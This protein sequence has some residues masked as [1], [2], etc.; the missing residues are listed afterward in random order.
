[1]PHKHSSKRYRSS[2]A[3]MLNSRIGWLTIFFLSACIV[4]LWPKFVF[5]LLFV[6]GIAILIF[7]FVVLANR[8]GF[9]YSDAAALV[10]IFLTLTILLAFNL[11][12]PIWQPKQY[13]TEAES[14]RLQVE[15]TNPISKN[16]PSHKRSLSQRALH[17]ILAI[18]REW[19]S[20]LQR[21]ATKLSTFN[22]IVIL[23]LLI[24]QS[25]IISIH[26]FRL[27]LFSWIPNKSFEFVAALES[28]LTKRLF[29][30]L[31]IE[32]WHS[33]LTGI[34]I[35]VALKL[36][37]FHS[38]LSYGIFTAFAVMIPRWG[39]VLAISLPTIQSVTTTGIGIHIIGIFLAFATTTLISHALFDQTLQRL[40]PNLSFISQILSL[41][42]AAIIAGLFGMLL[43]IPVI[44][45]FRIIWL[46]I[47]ESILY[48]DNSQCNTLQ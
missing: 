36:L 47:D 37:G 19:H 15:P 32:L 31:Y 9:E 23:V 40:R 45:V 46:M 22:W 7:P 11:A 48:L 8:C 4:L 42:L 28:K 14:L 27:K 16:T 44:S 35:T 20:S 6:T 1:M 12:G 13:G 29:A 38:A 2:I 21:F 33:L 25:L 5:V 3:A 34:L 26:G 30:Y 24:S 43:I 41:L 10:T 18:E 17:Q 39:V